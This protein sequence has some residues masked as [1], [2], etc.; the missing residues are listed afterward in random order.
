MNNNWYDDVEYEDN[1]IE[2]VSTYPNGY[3]VKLNDNR[4]YAGITKNFSVEPKVGMSIRLFGKGLG[5]V[6]RGVVLNGKMIFYK[7][8][9]EQALE[10]I[11]WFKQKTG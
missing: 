6:I 3:V 10:D 9:R 11:A 7:T 8:A 4:S 1:V 2:E 5:Y